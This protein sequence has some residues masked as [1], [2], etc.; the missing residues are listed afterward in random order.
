M[1]RFLL[2][3][4]LAACSAES[5]ALPP[6]DSGVEED[7]AEG[8][9]GSGGSG[10]EDSGLTDANLIGFADAGQDSG[11]TPEQDAG[12]DAG[13]A[14]D[15][16]AEELPVDLLVGTWDITETLCGALPNTSDETISI[17]RLDPPSV[18]LKGTA[19]YVLKPYALYLY[20][21]GD[22]L[23]TRSGSS[24][25]FWLVDQNTIGGM[26]DPACPEYVLTGT[27]AL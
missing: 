11:Q 26:R 20:E 14:H 18:G 16:A 21:E 7:A 13:E 25:R 8:F 2:P 27:R 3:L 4:F 5:P 23:E 1:K 17:E 15:G 6:E 12:Q 19:N 22:E 24:L 10:A 9:A